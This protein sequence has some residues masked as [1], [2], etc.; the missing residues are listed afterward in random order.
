MPNLLSFRLGRQCSC[1]DIYFPV[2]HNLGGYFK[3]YRYIKL[4]A[5]AVVVMPVMMIIA[6]IM[7]MVVT[8][9]VVV[10]VVAIIVIVVI[11][12]IAVNGI[13]IFVLICT[14]VI[15]HIIVDKF[16]YYAGFCV[17]TP[18][19]AGNINVKRP[20]IVLNFHRVYRLVR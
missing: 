11:V 10:M 18:A 14:V 2:G 3:N 7:V 1:S 9:V 17:H 13:E 19:G 16:Y 8:T 12:I 20:F 4:P 5:I 15:I 6:I